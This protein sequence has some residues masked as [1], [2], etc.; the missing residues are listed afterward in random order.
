MWD[1]DFMEMFDKTLETMEK[2]AIKKMKENVV[3]CREEAQKWIDNV[4]VIVNYLPPNAK[5]EFVAYNKFLKTRVEAFKA[6]IKA[7]NDFEKEI[8]V[9][10]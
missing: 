1:K 4:K 7:A 9:K 3:N 5:K 6:V 8:M 10:N 2:E